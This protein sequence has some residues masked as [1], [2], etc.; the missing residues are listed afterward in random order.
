[1][2]ILFLKRHKIDFVGWVNKANQ[3]GFNENKTPCIQVNKTPCIQVNK[4][5]CIQVNRTAYV[6]KERKSKE[7]F[8][9]LNTAWLA[10]F[11]D[12]EGCFSI[13][14]ID[15]S[16]YQ[17]G[18]RIRCRF[19]LDQLGEYF[20]FLKL[21]ELWGGFI[22]IRKTGNIHETMY[23]YTCS[24]FKDLRKVI[25]YLTKY[26]LQ[27]R[28]KQSFVRMVRMLYYM[29]HRKELAWNGK[30]LERVLNLCKKNES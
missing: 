8:D 21:K 26:S 11:I 25:N 19:L 24:S 5:P 2:E 13:Q 10:G 28:K 3:L 12:A 17:V 16:S 1:M 23:R 9:I 4:T 15:S 27:T 20:L 7:I 18:F 29:E 22:T 14:K 30:V 6:L